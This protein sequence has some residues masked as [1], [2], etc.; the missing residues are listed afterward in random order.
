[1]RRIFFVQLFRNIFTK[2]II[3]I[4]FKK[5][6]KQLT[7]ENGRTSGEHQEDIRKR[8]EKTILYNNIESETMQATLMQKEKFCMIYNWYLCLK[9]LINSFLFFVIWQKTKNQLSC[10]LLFT[11]KEAAVSAQLAVSVLYVEKKIII[12]IM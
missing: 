4:E 6:T 8:F 2:V 10:Y 11:K 9:Y 1:L 5:G 7:Q 12:K 3:N